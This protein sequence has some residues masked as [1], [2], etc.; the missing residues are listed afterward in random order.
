MFRR[1]FI[2]NVGITTG[3]V[4]LNSSILNA[5]TP[6]FKTKKINIA[7]IGCG[8]RGQ[9]LMQ[10]LNQLADQYEIKAICDVLDFRLAAAKKIAPAAG[11]TKDYR[12][13]LDNK[14][15]SAIIIAVPLY[16]HF[17]IARDALQ[18][19]KHIY[20][21]KT[22]TYNTQEA[23][24]L[25]KLAQSKPMQI[26]Q[27]GHQYRYTP[28]YYKVKDMI[29]KGYLGKVTQIDCRWDRN[30]SWRRPVPAA[31]LERQINWRMYKEYS[32]GLPA[33]LLSHQI[34]FV[35]WAFDTHVDEVFGTGGIDFYKDGRE[36]YDNVQAV[37][38]Y[39]KEGMI[40]NFG[41]TCANSHDGYL[42]KIKG[43][44]GSISLLMNEGIYYPEKEALKEHQQTVD[45]VTGATKIVWNKDGG[46]PILT[47]PIKDGSWYA[48]GDFH[49]S[50]STQQQPSSNVYTGAK[51]AFTVHMINESIFGNS[52]QKWKPEFDLI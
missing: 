44:K 11:I 25:V 36:T 16:L 50:I 18:A 52:I 4:L 13:I 3:A 33:E 31:G 10:V 34:D 39:N 14:D 43:S 15:I 32:G 8:D 9:G 7:V 45:G 21:E 49:K 37:L 22:M 41:A 38:R 51:T 46:I 48:L 12:K 19:G 27:V 42:F 6:S 20:L 40:G 47:E 24:E 30:G 35:N 1:N 26:L 5:V 17:Q 23:L 2:K 29:N 28:L